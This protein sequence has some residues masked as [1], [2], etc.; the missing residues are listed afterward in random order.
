MMPN[1]SD[2]IAEDKHGTI[3]TVEV[4]PGSKHSL[5]PAGYNPWRKAIGCHVT[6]PP[7]EG[8]ANRAVIGL[9]ADFVAIPRTHVEII[10]GA[11]G[12]IKRVRIR[13]I[14]YE[15]LSSALRDRLG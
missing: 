8:K 1:I 11:A 6:V 12:S 3:I 14:S 2:A 5:F 4:T 15:A 10:T 13:G 9:I 7:V